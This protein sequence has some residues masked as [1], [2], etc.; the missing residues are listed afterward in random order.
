[1]MSFLNRN[2]W[3]PAQAACPWT[4]PAV[5]RQLTLTPCRQQGIGTSL[6]FDSKRTNT[7]FQFTVTN[8]KL[9]NLVSRD[10]PK[11]PQGGQP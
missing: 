9:A 11:F 10:P 3:Y 1:M 6:G 8:A 4:Q 2:F 7:G 5:G